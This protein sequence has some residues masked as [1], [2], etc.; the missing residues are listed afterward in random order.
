MPGGDLILSGGTGSPSQPGGKIRFATTNGLAAPIDQMTIT[1]N[2]DVGIGITSPGEK[3]HVAGNMRATGQVRGG[4]Y[5]AGTGTVSTSINFNNGNT[6][7][8]EVNS[9]GCGGTFNLNGLNPGGEYTLIIKNLMGSVCDFTS[10]MLPSGFTKVIMSGSSTLTNSGNNVRIYKIT[11]TD[12]VAYIS[13]L[14]SDFSGS[15]F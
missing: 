1:S 10:P 15:T 7:K 5:Y 4:F 3:L 2:G 6:I 9:G 14:P 8:Y 12:S 11:V 13:W